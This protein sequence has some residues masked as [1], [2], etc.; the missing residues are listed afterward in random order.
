MKNVYLIVMVSVVGLLLSAC[1]GGE[2][3]F[4]TG[5]EKIT[6]THCSETY[7][8]TQLNDL[9]IKDESDTTIEVLHDVNGTKRVCVLTGSAH[10][11][12]EKN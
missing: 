7:I 2:G 12:R 8:T 6:I 1:S 5:E 3:S 10:I 9:L 4:D 11:I